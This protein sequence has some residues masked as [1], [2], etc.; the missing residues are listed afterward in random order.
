MTF[1]VSWINKG[2]TYTPP[3]KREL[4]PIRVLAGYA[5]PHWLPYACHMLFVGMIAKIVLPFE[6]YPLA[7]I[8][9]AI[10]LI[11]FWLRGRYPELTVKNL[12]LKDWLIAL[13]VGVVG[14]VLWI[15]PYHYLNT[16]MFARI[17]IWGNEN[18]Y[19]SFTYGFDFPDEAFR[20]VLG[21][22]VMVP[23][24]VPNATYSP[25]ILEQSVGHIAS[26]LFGD[27]AAHTEMIRT[28]LVAM[29]VAGAVLTVPLFEELFI[30]SAV[31]RFVTDEYYQ[32][33]PIGY[34]TRK[35]FLIALGLYVVAHPWWLVALI[36]GGLTFWLY[37]YRKN[38]VLCIF[39]HGVSNLLLAWYV[40]Q[41]G[42]FYL[43]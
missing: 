31:V 15:A 8:A 1:N 21:G 38:L 13:V 22:L 26:L 32:R 4:M 11:V 24:K 3:A 7:V 37:Y 9:T 43:W 14:I 28:G 42:H 20:R 10:V 2:L 40:L 18:I 5:L 25:A 19:L 30:R 29:R 34:F 41:T 12:T 23:V 6:A 17:P 33:V 35:S 16:L 27:A 39:A 36:W